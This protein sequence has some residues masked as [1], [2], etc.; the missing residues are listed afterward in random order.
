MPDGLANVS[1][2]TPGDFGYADTGQQSRRP[3]GR[4]CCQRS[5]TS[6]ASTREHCSRRRT[7]CLLPSSSAP[8][9]I[10]E[11][12]ASRRSSHIAMC[13]FHDVGPDYAHFL[14]FFNDRLAACIFSCTENEARNLGRCLAAIMAD[15]D[16]W[17]A[18]EAKYKR[19]GQG[20]ADPPKD[21]NDV[22]QS[23][24][25]RS[26]PGMQARL[27][28]GEP[29][30]PMVWTGFRNLYGKFHNTLAKVSHQFILKNHRQAS[31]HL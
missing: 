16:V 1:C 18:D 30:R 6:T 5:S 14:Q 27:R 2:A 7:P 13:V 20:L 28:P 29:M 21:A 23:A 11:R 10:W 22:S 4:A 25:V 31:S 3:T 19:E 24:P 17:H 12:L 15:L 8:H 9:M 26:L